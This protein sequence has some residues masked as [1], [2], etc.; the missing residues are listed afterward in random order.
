MYI[1]IY[2]CTHVHSFLSKVLYVILIIVSQFQKVKKNAYMSRHA[3]P[4]WS[5]AALSPS[6][7]VK[8]ENTSIPISCILTLLS[9]NIRQTCNK[10]V[11]P[12]E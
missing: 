8:G 1:Y 11:I 10:Y 2:T 6:I 9:L 5:G 12:E 3:V 7:G 4:T